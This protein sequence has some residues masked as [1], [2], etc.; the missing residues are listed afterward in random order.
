MQYEVLSFCHRP[1][2]GDELVCGIGRKLDR[3]GEAAG[4]TGIAPDE[5]LHLIRVTRDNDDDAVAIVLHEFEQGINGLLAEI[6]TR[7]GKRIRFIDEQDAVERFPAFVE[8]LGSGLADIAR[9]ETRAISLDQMT[10]SQ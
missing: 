2:D 5:A 8:R 3:L 4:K 1:Q 9:D 10:F 6:I 7:S